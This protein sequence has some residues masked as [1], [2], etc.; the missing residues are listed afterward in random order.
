[1]QTQTKDEHEENIIV[2]VRVKP[3][4]EDESSEKRCITIDKNSITLDSRTDL[5]TFSFDY[6][7]NEKVGQEEI[8]ERAGRSLADACIKGTPSCFTYRI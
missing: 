4:N 6:I 7:A 5:R 2:M 8:F 3:M 1:M